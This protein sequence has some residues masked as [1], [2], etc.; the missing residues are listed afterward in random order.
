MLRPALRV[1]RGVWYYARTIARQM[2]EVDILFLASGLA[3]NAVL[4]LIPLMLLIASAIGMF[5]NSSSLGVQHLHDVLDAVF[6]PQPFAQEIRSSVLGIVADIVVYRTSLGVFGILV[7]IWTTLSLFDA[8]RSVLHRVYA[9]KRTRGLLTSLFHDLGFLILAFVFFLAVNFTLWISDLAEGVAKGIPELS[10]VS[11]P[12]VR[13]YLPAAVVLL[14]AGLMFYI[15]YRF[16]TDQKPPTIAALISTVT[17]TLMWLVSGKLFAVYLTELSNVTALY[18]T[19]A[20]LVVFLVW[21]YY[22]SLIFVFGAIVG[23][24]HWQRVRRFHPEPGG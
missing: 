13:S 2:R 20:F 22:S 7:L 4:S 1:A 18:G 19:Y 10:R 24:V 16:M 5:L 6:P 23:Q 21:I 11:M 9:L 15:L 8:I 14:L 17:S 3:F 12:P